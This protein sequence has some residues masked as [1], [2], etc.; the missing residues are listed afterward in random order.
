MCM[1]HLCAERVPSEHGTDGRSGRREGGAAVSKSQAK[2]RMGKAHTTAHPQHL[3]RF[4][5]ETCGGICVDGQL[6][7][8]A[9]CPAA[10]FHSAV[11]QSCWKQ[12]S[13]AA[14]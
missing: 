3:C 8:A 4:E 1:W 14:R 6:I 2:C 12:N 10:L 7:C 9:S 5:R 11:E 13:Q